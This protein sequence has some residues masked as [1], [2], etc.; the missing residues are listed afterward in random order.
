MGLH[1]LNPLLAAL[2]GQGPASPADRG[3]G[4]QLLSGVQEQRMHIVD[5]E[6]LTPVEARVQEALRA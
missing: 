6:V 2:R 3:S 1:L 5:W 4:A